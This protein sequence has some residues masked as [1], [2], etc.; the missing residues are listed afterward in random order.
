M[1]LFFFQVKS[2]KEKIE[3]EKGSEDY[4]AP[5]QKLIYAGKILGKYNKSCGGSTASPKRVIYCD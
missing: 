4:P 1:F 2:L 3:S 5:H